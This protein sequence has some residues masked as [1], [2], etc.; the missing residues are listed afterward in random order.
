MNFILKNKIFVFLFCFIFL[1]YFLKKY[2]FDVSVH[3]D[4]IQNKKYLK[5]KHKKI[6]SL[7]PHNIS[8]IIKISSASWYWT[9]VRVNNLLFGIWI[10]LSYDKLIIDIYGIDNGII[11]SNKY[12]IDSKDYIL[13]IYKNS[14]NIKFKN[15]VEYIYDYKNKKIN[16][17]VNTP[18]INANI[19]MSYHD[20]YTSDTSITPRYWFLK[21]KGWHGYMQKFCNLEKFIYNGKSYKNGVVYDD[22]FVSEKF[23]DS[24]TFL[25][26]ENKK[27]KILLITSEPKKIISVKI[28]NILKKQYLFVG[29]ITPSM[30]YFSNI[31]FKLNTK[32]NYLNLLEKV[33]CN[34]D[35]SVFKLIIKSKNIRRISKWDLDQ[36]K[37]GQIGEDYNLFAEIKINYKGKNEYYKD[38]IYFSMI[39]NKNDN[40]NCINHPSEKIC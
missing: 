30:N 10:F 26:Y 14:C 6:L 8:K 3:L 21:N 19:I 36:Y 7:I 23:F 28:F 39:K 33:I 29:S 13:K 25:H 34:F 4:K 22:V 17:F 18:N 24:Y 16:C 40:W 15:F 1:L 20:F 37:I 31:L 2:Y 5:K 35:S 12:T 38:Y 9:Y 27:W 11:F 32:I